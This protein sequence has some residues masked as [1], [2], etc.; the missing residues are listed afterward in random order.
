MSDNPAI[1][2]PNDKMPPGKPLDDASAVPEGDGGDASDDAG[3]R[4][5]AEDDERQEPKGGGPSAA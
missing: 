3:G 5:G 4:V 1:E 2:N